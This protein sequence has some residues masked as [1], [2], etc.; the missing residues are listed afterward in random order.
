MRRVDPIVFSRKR[1]VVWVCDVAGSS[2]AFNNPDR[3]DSVEAYLPRLL[4]VA[5]QMV[6]A[7][8][9]KFI[10]WT[11]DGFL[12][13]FEVEIERERGAVAAKVFDAAWHLSFTNNVTGLGLSETED[14]PFRLRHGVAWEPDALI[15][16]IEQ[17]NGS[18][19]L[20]MLGR[21]IVLAFRLSGI[22]VDFPH[23]V[24]QSSIAQESERYGRSNPGFEDLRL[25]ED[26][27]L[28]YFKGQRRGVASIVGSSSARKTLYSKRPLADQIV[29]GTRFRNGKHNRRYDYE[30]MVKRY[31]LNLSNGNDWTRKILNDELRFIREEM[32]EALESA[33][34][35]TSESRHISPDLRTSIAHILEKALS[36]E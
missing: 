12:A 28:K 33:I 24:T 23:I 6:A 2:K 36:G 7:A 34:N 17:E 14:S 32:I 10:K 29:R 3:A 13:W 31:V 15:M 35:H 27:I 5:R 4:W 30:E 1:G 21:D 22:Q 26:D 19:S 18:R 11:G 20:D 8:N 9:G 25:N 16:D